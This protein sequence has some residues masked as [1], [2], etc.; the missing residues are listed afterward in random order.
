MSALGLQKSCAGYRGFTLIELIVVLV[1]LS[2]L[3]VMGAQFVVSSTQNYEATRTRALLVNTGRA[4]LERM[5][6]QLR[7]A[8]PYSVQ[9]TNGG[10]CVRFMPIAGGG[11]YASPVPDAANGAAA[12]ASIAVLPHGVEFG[13]A[14]W[15]SIGAMSA[16]ELYS[17]NQSIAALSG[18]SATSLTLDGAKSWARNS[19]NRRFYL[20]DNPQAFC[21]VNNELR[22]YSNL[23][24]TD[25]NVNTGGDS[26][27]LAKQVNAP[28]PF[29][30]SPES[31]NRNTLVLIDISFVSGG[32]SVEFQ[33]QVMIRNVP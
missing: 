27:L 11:T 8:L 29:A 12:S 10:D 32:E 28:T 15:V 2:I 17:G 26:D 7:G 22:F 19:I 30:L 14:N 3:A 1:V 23:T 4:A 13:S 21:V 25:A 18:R 20:L 5:N 24:R 9:I 31:E 16:G 6:R 33:Q